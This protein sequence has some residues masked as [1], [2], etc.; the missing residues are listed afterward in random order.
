MK[1]G[2]YGIFCLKTGEV[3]VGQAID[4]DHR[5]GQHL[6][7]LRHRRHQCEKLQNAWVKHGES[8]FEVR[9]IE[10]VEDHNCL[11]ARERYWIRKFGS[12]AL[13]ERPGGPAGYYIHGM[14]GT[15]TFK[16]WESMKQRCTNP[17]SP[18]YPKWGGKGI[19]VC[20][21]WL[22]FKNFYADMGVR[23]LG[24]TLDRF[25]NK[26]GNYEPGNCRWATASQQQKNKG[27]SIYITHD[28]VTKP[29]VEWAAEKGMPNDLLRRRYH[30][31]MIGNELFA[32]SYS[33]Y[34][35]DGLG[36]KRK[37]TETRHDLHRFAYN[38]KQLTI[39][40]ISELT[41]LS[42]DT[43]WQR[44][45]KYGMPIEKALTA[46]PL[47]KGKEGPRKGHNI[48]K[49]FGK[50]QSLTAWA[51]EYGLPLSTL[52]NRIYRAGLSPEEALKSS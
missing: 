35:G 42:Y 33:R 37:R 40:E 20:D 26:K 41:E 21:W 2:I 48:I 16:S 30:A 51:R 9:L 19:T 8:Q 12:K 43:L 25:P 46:A 1:C 52:K 49:A 15:P 11:A 38:G 45:V 28:G 13:N 32:P 24:M 17:N 4:L 47:K 34:A 29:L 44:L 50:E 5:W 36:V 7:R 22:E 18:D 3:Y 39:R 6:K 14:T 31:G 23:P 10:A 27:N